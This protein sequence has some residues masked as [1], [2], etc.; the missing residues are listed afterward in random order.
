NVPWIELASAFQMQDRLLP[1][2]ASALDHAER[3][4]HVRLVRQ[5]A[6]R[7]DQFANRRLVIACGIIVIKRKREM[8]FAEVGPQAQSHLRGRF[9]FRQA[10][11]T[12]VVAKPK[13]LTMNARGKIM[14]Q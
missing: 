8:S 2:S 13:E 7:E 12:L 1:A 4:G 6:L 9:R 11:P 5:G 10:R 3:A 14:R